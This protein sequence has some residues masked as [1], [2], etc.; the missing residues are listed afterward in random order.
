MNM[1]ADGRSLSDLWVLALA[2]L[3]AVILH[4]PLLS[5]GFAEEDYRLFENAVEWPVQEGDSIGPSWSAILSPKAIGEAETPGRYGPL[6]PAAFLFELSLS[7]GNAFASHLV[8]LAL[9][10]VGGLLLG[11]LLRLLFPDLSGLGLA[12]CVGLYLAYPSQVDVLA[13]AAYR[14]ATLAWIC[15]GLALAMRV[16]RPGAL[17]LPASLVVLGLFADESTLAFLPALFLGRRAPGDPSS[18]SADRVGDRRRLGFVLFGIAAGYVALRATIL[19]GPSGIIAALNGGGGVGAWGSRMIDALTAL[20]FPFP[21]SGDESLLDRL[22]MMLA[23]ALSCAW[24]VTRLANSGAGK[25]RR[26]VWLA[27]SLMVIPLV[28]LAGVDDARPEPGRHPMSSV[29]VAGL[30]ILLAASIKGATRP[31]TFWLPV[32]AFSVSFILLDRAAQ[33]S[34]LHRQF[35]LDGMLESVDEVLIREESGAE[36]RIAVLSHPEPSKSG[37]ARPTFGAL[38]ASLRVPFAKRSRTFHRLVDHEPT[39]RHDAS[40]RDFLGDPKEATLVLMFEP[41]R[42]QPG[43]RSVLP[44]REIG[45]TDTV[46]ELL[47]VE[48]HQVIDVDLGAPEVSTPS[49]RF[50]LRGTKPDR[51]VIRC[52]TARRIS[53]EATM[54]PEQLVVPNGSGNE[55]Y[56]IRFPAASFTAFP[57]GETAMGWSLAAMDTKDRILARTATRVFVLRIR[58]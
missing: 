54:R 15:G 4:W 35:E 17:A 48:Q 9:Y 41:E 6:V 14:G 39:G 16:R 13:A 31:K 44:G 55:L 10:L 32:I 5:A 29:A 24:I 58:R 12:L 57:S 56:Q 45:T 42:E 34:R 21:V 2:C 47:G 38:A 11:V 3:G 43:F 26:I 50:H 7:N 23:L 51:L 46:I 22:P 36:A 33:E 27:A 1:R 37:R 28:A 8:N 49:L 30:V 25:D 53:A 20:V 52:F 40:L 18:E 19:G